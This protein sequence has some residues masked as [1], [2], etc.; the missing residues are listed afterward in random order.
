MY[1]YLILIIFFINGESSPLKIK[2]MK[3]L[4]Y[5][6]L[7][8]AILGGTTV[9]GQTTISYYTGDADTLT[10]SNQHVAGC[11]CQSCSWAATKKQSYEFFIITDELL[12]CYL[13]NS[14]VICVFSQHSFLL[15]NIIQIEGKTVRV[16]E[17]GDDGIAFIYDR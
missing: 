9:F 8:I 2:I 6:I 3:K 7:I 11:R 5:S 4:F 13:K 10:I 17:V 1:Y 12:V 15:R 16:Y 14:N